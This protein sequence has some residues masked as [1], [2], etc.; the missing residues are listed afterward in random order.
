MP[1]GATP[2]GRYMPTPG[3]RITPTPDTTGSLKVPLLVAPGEQGGA[4]ILTVVDDNYLGRS[5]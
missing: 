1:F 5:H 4:A 3:G 2:S